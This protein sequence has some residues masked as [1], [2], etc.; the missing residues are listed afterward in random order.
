MLNDFSCSASTSTHGSTSTTGTTSTATGPPGQTGSTSFGVPTS[1]SFSHSTR[2]KIIASTSSPSPSSTL[3]QQP[4]A[5]T[6]TVPSVTSSPQS[7]ALR[8]HSSLQSIDDFLTQLACNSFAIHP[9]HTRISKPRLAFSPNPS[10]KDSHAYSWTSHASSNHH[11]ISAISCLVGHYILAGL[12]RTPAFI[13][14]NSYSRLRAVG[15]LTASLHSSTPALHPSYSPSASTA[16]GSLAHPI[17]SSTPRSSASPT[18]AA[19]S[20]E[21]APPLPSSSSPIPINENAPPLWGIDCK[22]TELLNP[23]KSK[24][25]YLDSAGKL[26]I[27]DLAS[28]NLQNPGSPGIA[29]RLRFQPN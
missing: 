3:S 12:N 23:D 9:N 5:V 24:S 29:V 25:A 16:T 13:V 27:G 14:S 8:F 22:T 10:D 11:F 7:Y 21:V 20:Q 6:S 15:R 4:P 28:Y 18:A 17:I 19:P 26:H 1:T 2:I